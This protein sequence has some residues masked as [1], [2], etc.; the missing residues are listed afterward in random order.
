MFKKLL[1]LVALALPA[2]A[3]YDDPAHLPAKTDSAHGQTGYNDVSDIERGAR[4]A[5]GE[6]LR[7]WL[8]T[9]A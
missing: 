8:L 6:L 1:F 5:C 7:A 3:E 9:S 2:L 4:G